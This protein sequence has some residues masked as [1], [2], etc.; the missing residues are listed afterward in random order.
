MRMYLSVL[1][2][3][4]AVLFITPLAAFAQEEM[5]SEPVFHYLTVTTFDAPGGEE[6]QKMRDYFETVAAPLA[7]LNPN[8]LSYRVAQH[9]WGS[10]PHRS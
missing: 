2:A 5:E 6:G 1:I 10:T 7:K 9:N 3:G 4:A 8:V